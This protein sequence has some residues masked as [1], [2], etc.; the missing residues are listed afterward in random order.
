MA[1]QYGN[2]GKSVETLQEQLNNAGVTRLPRLKLDGNFDMLVMARVMEFQ[3]KSRFP[4][5]SIDG[6]V[7]EITQGKLNATPK[8]SPIPS[9]RCIVVDLINEKLYAYN[10]GVCDLK[11]RRIK[12][13]D[14]AN[15]SDRGVFK[16]YKRLRYHTSSLYPEPPG[17]MDCALF[18]NKGEALHQGPVT[19]YSHGCIHVKPRKA[20]RLFNWAASHDTNVIVVKIKR[21]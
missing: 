10:D 5:A 7:S 19:E 8:S 6:V 21:Y 3:F 9:K 17:N 15:P 12:G 4:I 1:L 20:E 2:S 11:F 13:G 14:A 16:V 18:Y